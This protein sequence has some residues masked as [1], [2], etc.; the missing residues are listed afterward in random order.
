LLPVA[1]DG[2]REVRCAV[3][4]MRMAAFVLASERTPMFNDGDSSS[5]IRAADVNLLEHGGK[6]Y[7]LASPMASLEAA[8]MAFID[9]FRTHGE[10]HFV[11]EDVLEANGFSA[12]L[13]WLGQGERGELGTEFCPWSAFWL[14]DVDDCSIVGISS[15]RHSLSSWMQERGGHVGYRI[16]PSRRGHGFAQLLLCQM[17]RL[18]QARGITEL[19]VVCHDDNPASAAVIERRGGAEYAPIADGARMLRRFRIALQ[20]G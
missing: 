10:G 14:V 18:A 9:E 5:N 7:L 16:R 11:H 6:R 3:V 19:M 17:E 13:A 2:F 15:L 12:Y 8:Y 20:A 4:V 1:D